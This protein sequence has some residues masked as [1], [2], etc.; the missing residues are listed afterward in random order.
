[1][2]PFFNLTNLI[3]A[4]TNNFHSQEIVFEKG[5]KYRRGMHIGYWWDRQKERYH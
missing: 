1:L 4:P 3:F 5:E 2:Y